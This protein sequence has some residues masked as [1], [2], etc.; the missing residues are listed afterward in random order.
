MLLACEKPMPITGFA[1]R[2]AMRRMA[3]I[4]CEGNGGEGGRPPPSKPLLFAKFANAVIADGAA[5][6]GQKM[7]QPE[8]RGNVPMMA[9][10]TASQPTS[11]RRITVTFSPIRVAMKKKNCATGG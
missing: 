10:V 8:V 11:A 2:P 6:T 1:P 5:G 3:F 9:T 7:S 4:A